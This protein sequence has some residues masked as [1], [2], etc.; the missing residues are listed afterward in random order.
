MNIDE[1]AA[2]DA[3]M[4]EKCEGCGEPSVGY[5]SEGVPLCAE[6]AAICLDPNDESLKQKEITKMVQTAVVK[7]EAEMEAER[8]RG[9]RNARGAMQSKNHVMEREWTGYAN[10]IRV[11]LNAWRRLSATHR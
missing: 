9:D 10:G 8:K 7:W 4:A 1:Q 6:C 2:A 3:I 11:A 5:D